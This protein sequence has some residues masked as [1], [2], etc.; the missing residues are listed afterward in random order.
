[1]NP[2]FLTGRRQR[3]A[4]T[5]VELLVVIGIIAVLIGLLLPVFNKARD[6]SLTTRC[7]AN[8][9]QNGQAVAAYLADSHGYLPPYMLP[10]PFTYDA[11]PYIFQWLPAFYLNAAA[12]TWVCPV[13]NLIE[14]LE[15]GQRGP[16]PELYTGQ[17][18]VFY[19]YAENLDQPIRQT[20][21]YPATATFEYFNPGLAMRVRPSSEFMFL[22]ETS[23]DAMQGYGSPANYFRFDHRHRTVMNV[24]FM[25]G[26]VDAKT[27]AEM[28][29]GTP[30]A[31]WSGNLRAFWFGQDSA[32]Q[33][34]LY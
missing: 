27:V 9:R 25:D 22:H 26:H 16:Y 34:Q 29:P 6:A 15:G 8:L 13:D 11:Q 21:L 32:I 33:Q 23:E 7:A 31:L 19:S 20:P 1:M 14:A 10:G 24:L 30:P 12:K 5:L 18:D 4:F 28:F 2:H 17:A 3:G